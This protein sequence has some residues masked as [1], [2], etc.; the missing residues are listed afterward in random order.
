MENSPGLIGLLPVAAIIIVYLLMRYYRRW[1]DRKIRSTPLPDDMLGC[2]ERSLSFYSALSTPDQERLR[3]KMKLFLADKT[4][5]GCND[6]VITDEMR[7]II[8]AEACLLVL[9]QGGEIYPG[10]TAILVYPS[11]F[12]AR[13]EEMS[14]DGTLAVA[15]RDLLGESWDTGKVVL[16]WDAVAKGVADFTDG[17]NVVLHEFAHQLDSSSGR[18][19]GAPPLSRNS[20]KNWARVLSA[21]YEDLRLRSQRALPTVI[22]TY[23]ATNPAEFFAVATETFFERP[24]ELHHRRPELFEQLSIYYRLDPRDWAPHEEP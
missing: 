16:A 5:Y 9:N 17:N 14:E 15:S 8:A 4:F 7:A 6:L 23:G 22:D 3:E 24:H 1:K 21:N 2:L 13:R 12:I 10:L 18:T 20:Y 11:T 19:N